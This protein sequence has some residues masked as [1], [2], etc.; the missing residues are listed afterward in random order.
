MKKDREIRVLYTG[1]EIVATIKSGQISWI[2]HIL[3]RQKGIRLI[4][5]WNHTK[6]KETIGK[7]EVEIE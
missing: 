2:G 7:T 3:G 5:V 4:E 6:R 1:S